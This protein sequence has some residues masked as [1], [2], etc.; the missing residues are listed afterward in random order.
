MS[1]VLLE[2]WRFDLSLAMS[3]FVVAIIYGSGLSLFAAIGYY[4]LALSVFEK[5]GEKCR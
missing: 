2:S 5:S 1:D 3:L 4:Y